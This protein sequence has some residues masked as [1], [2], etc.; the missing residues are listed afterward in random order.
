MIINSECFFDALIKLHSNEFT[1]LLDLD[2]GPIQRDA[3]PVFTRILEHWG[4][5]LLQVIVF[6]LRLG[7]DVNVNIGGAGFC[8]RPEVGDTRPVT[9]RIQ[10]HWERF[11]VQVMAFSELLPRLANDININI[12]GSP[13]S[14]A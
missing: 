2:S 9:S 5:F 13:L 8:Q 12:G 11:L 10:G 3:W 4:R 6:L 1:R 14:K 7:N